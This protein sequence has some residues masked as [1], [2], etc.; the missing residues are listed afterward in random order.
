MSRTF[1]AHVITD[2]S[3][4]GGSVIQRSLRFY[5]SNSAYLNR[6]PSSAGD[7]RTWTWSGWVKRSNSDT[8]MNLFSVREAS[9]VRT[10]IRITDGLD[11]LDDD[12]NFRL[13]T[14]AKFRDVSAWYHF[15]VVANTTDSTSSNRLKVYVNGE[16]ITSFSTE[17][18][19]SQNYEGQINTTNE[20]ALGREGSTDNDYLDGY[21]AEVNF[22]DGYAYDPS[23]FGYTESQTGLWRPK[24]YEG[25]YGTNGFHLDFSDNSSTSALGIDKSPNG[26][27]WSA[28]NFTTGANLVTNGEFN[29]D[30]DW[31]KDSSWTISGG[32]ASNS[33]GGEI[34][35]TFAVV[36]GITYIMKATVDA[37]GD[38]ALGNTSIGFRDTSDTQF[39][40]Y[41]ATFANGSFTDLTANAVNEVV[42]PWTSTVT[43]NVRAR[44]YSSDTITIDNWS[45]IEIA[46]SVTDTP[47]NNFP[48]MNPLQRGEDN[49][50][51]A[52][53]N[54]Y[55]GGPTDH[56]IVA[57][58]P[59]PSSGKW[60]WE[61]TKTADTNLMSG[62]IGDPENM[63]FSQLGTYVGGQSGGYSVYAQ[64]GRTYAAGSDATYMATPPTRTTI[65][66]A[67]DADTRRLYFGADG[68]W[69]DGSGNT[70]ETFANAA[71]AH[72][73]AAGKTYYPAGGFNGG[74]AFANFGQQRFSFT[75]PTGYKALSSRNLPPNVPSIIRPQKHFETLLYTGTD[76]SA[77]RT[78]TGFEFAPGLIWQKRRNGTNW[79]TW[80][81]TSRGVGKELFSNSVAAETTNNQ[82]GY[83]SSFNKDGF[84][85]SP[86]STNNSDGNE[87]SGT[88][89]SWCWKAGGAA[90]SNSDGSIT[91]SVSANQ[92]GGFSIVTWTGTNGTGTIGHGL[93]KEP[94]WIVIRRRDSESSWVVYH[95]GVGNTKRLTLDSIGAE[96]SASAN[97][98]NN[99][100]PT[101]TTFSVGSDGGSNGSTDG[102]VAWCWSEIPGF[103][104]FG[105]YFGNG[106]SDGTYVHLGFKPAWVMVKRTSSTDSWLILDN[107][108]DIDNPATQTQA[109]Q[110]NLQDN[111]NTG[112]IP[113]DFLSNG[114][115]CRGSGGDYN[116][117]GQTYIYMAFAEQPGTTP[118]D[119]FPNA[120]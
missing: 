94:K 33:G 104:K 30:S 93:G 36:S 57:T 60:Y 4:L 91:S 75:P 61:Y 66:I 45:V 31:T 7:R 101:S 98:F 19:P 117:S 17:T 43:G 116:G 8:N 48:V 50:T 96:S 86:G 76:T 18:Y 14:D 55:F 84:T 82:Y 15:V 53:G 100:S 73:V 71:V 52:D 64:N 35:Q 29:S 106:S 28:N 89:V 59:I 95:Y 13:K 38:S 115:K 3:A 85:W 105:K 72:T 27:D 9:D 47:T 44:C 78:I 68:H 11:F 109:P 110:S 58:F 111:L 34:Y 5:D 102:Y 69:G 88:F 54:L 119:T 97:W 118:F 74:S 56:A 12:F 77:A 46:D 32:K 65:M 10:I 42:I 39:Y 87:S 49:P 6:T 21:M 23:Y 63:N 26:N 83:I 20:H 112:G 1:P 81:D 114:F 67:Y 24:K 90:V 99:T 113:T 22:V 107:K 62:V 37:T 41:Q 80:F 2:D 79:H 92:E 108:R 25:T 51:V 70:D 40:A 103:S 120:R 16:Q